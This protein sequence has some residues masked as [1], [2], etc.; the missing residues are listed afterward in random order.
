MSIWF[1]LVAYQLKHFIADYPLQSNFYMLGKFRDKGWVKP[2]AAHAAVHAAGT[3]LISALVGRPLL[4]LALAVF[5]GVVHFTMDRIKAS[6]RLLG[7]FKALSAQEMRVELRY[8]A[9]GDSFAKMNI[10]DNTLFW[11]CLGLDQMV[12]HLTHY[13]CIAALV[14]M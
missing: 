10:R 14:L 3:L 8:L 5:D 13:A 4:G 12:H 2:L 9:E 7:R 1:L 6:N 11:N